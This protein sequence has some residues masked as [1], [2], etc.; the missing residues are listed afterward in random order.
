[1]KFISFFILLVAAL[2]ISA[3]E[4][5]VTDSPISNRS[6][7]TLE[8]SGGLN[9][10]FDKGIQEFNKSIRIIN[11]ENDFYLLDIQFN[12]KTLDEF[13]RQQASV[14]FDISFTSGNGIFPVGNYVL[15][16]EQIE[17][18]YGNYE[19]VKNNGDFARYNFEGV[20]ATLVIEESDSVHIKGSFILNMEQLYGKRMTD[21]QLEDVILISP[22]RLQ[23]HFNLKF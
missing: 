16:N 6:N 8:Y 5:T 17:S 19:L 2:I 22:I 4:S 3:C 11:Q 12:V 13:Q 15:T 1:M 23:S 20:S 18:A 10:T 14:Q 21:G 7:A 9:V